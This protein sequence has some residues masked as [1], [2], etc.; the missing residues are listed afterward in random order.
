MHFDL[1][2]DSEL[3]K[4]VHNNMFVIQRLRPCRAYIRTENK[5]C[6]AIVELLTTV[7]CIL[8]YGIDDD[9]FRLVM[10]A[11]FI[12]S[13]HFIHTMKGSSPLLKTRAPI[14]TIRRGLIEFHRGLTPKLYY[15]H[16]EER[17]KPHNRRRDTVED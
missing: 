9:S 10:K 3:S 15:N 5:M 11:F 14:T 13:L 8:Y 17:Q 7:L 1:Q 4:K 16:M 2:K 6:I 12:H